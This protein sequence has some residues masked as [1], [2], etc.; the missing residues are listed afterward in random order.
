MVLF[1]N[2]T[3]F[4]FQMPQSEF[5]NIAAVNKCNG[6][7]CLLWMVLSCLILKDRKFGQM[8]RRN[9]RLKMNTVRGMFLQT[10]TA[11]KMKFLFTLSLQHLLKQS[12]DVNKYSDHQ[13]KH[14]FVFRQI[15]LNS[16]HKS[17]SEISKEN[18]NV[19]IRA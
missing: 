3:L 8:P 14:V 11:T 5:E 12:S 16:F 6:R 18:N 4:A 7:L 9:I 15:L 13:G 19:Y 2:F 17:C 10:L 1:K